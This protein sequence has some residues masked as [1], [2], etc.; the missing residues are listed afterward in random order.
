MVVERVGG[1]SRTICQDV[2][3]LGLQVEETVLFGGKP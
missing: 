2:L 1:L 3:F